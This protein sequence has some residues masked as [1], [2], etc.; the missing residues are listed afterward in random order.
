[1]T[2]TNRSLKRGSW[3]AACAVCGFVFDSVK[4]KKRWD[5]VYVCEEDWEPRNILD[6]F[7]V[8]E[9]RLSVPW[10]QHEGDSITS[11]IE[12]EN[13]DSPY[14]QTTSINVIDVDATDGNVTVNL[15]LAADYTFADEFQLLIRRTDATA[16]TVTVARQGADTING[17]ASITIPIHGS[18]RLQNDASTAWRT[19]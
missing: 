19:V 9:E 14:T 15:A 18:I 2:I 12:V 5:G 4:L 16:N 6:F 3:S 7:K 11:Y 10:S 1:M 13:A 8:K 17:G